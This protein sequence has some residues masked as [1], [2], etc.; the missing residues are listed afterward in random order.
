MLRISLSEAQKV[1]LEKLR[2]NRASNIGERAYIIL[3]AGSGLSA[4]AIAKLLCR[5]IHTIR[6]WINRYLSSG[7]SGLESKKQ[8]GRTPVKAEIIEGKIDALLSKSP[9]DY[10]YQESAWQVSIL[11]DWFDK[12]EGCRACPNTM[13]KALKRKG[14]IYKRFSKT[15]PANAPSA[16]KKKQRVSKMID[17]ILAFS[18]E[19]TEIF[20]ADESHFSNQ[21][22]VSKGWFVRGEKK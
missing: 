4:P 1:A 6:L 15:T 9:Q 2:L 14:F 21:P 10:G 5:N 19:E 7:I 11:C 12:N 18:D 20:F 17:D 22:Y 13:V 8:P 16:A 3:L